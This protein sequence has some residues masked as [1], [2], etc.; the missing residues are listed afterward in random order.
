MRAPSFPRKLLVLGLGLGLLG[1]CLLVLALRS[2]GEANRLEP[3]TPPTLETA[4]VP[5]DPV[6]ALQALEVHG[7]VPYCH[8]REQLARHS[9][10]GEDHTHTYVPVKP[11]P[12]LQGHAERIAPY[13]GH[14]SEPVVYR[15]ATLLCFIQDT[16][17][18]RALAW[19]ASR[20]TCRGWV[21]KVVSGAG[22]ALPAKRCEREEPQGGYALLM[23]PIPPGPRRSRPETL[24]LAE[25]ISKGEATAVREA[26]HATQAMDL[27][28]RW[29]AILA[30]MNVS[31]PQGLALVLQALLEK[32]EEKVLST[33]SRM[34][35]NEAELLEGVGGAALRNVVERTGRTPEAVL[36][37]TVGLMPEALSRSMEGA[38]REDAP[39][40]DAIRRYAHSPEGREVTSDTARRFMERIKDN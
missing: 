40:R 34:G 33:R 36:V 14:P 5:A 7:D 30:L 24:V 6:R 38:L 37:E 35:W 9:D 11:L 29:E 27:E 25:R 13:L 21:R 20:Y 12:G 28:Q 2:Q 3:W 17:S 18:R 32:W 10:E 8:P 4:G 15:A 16:Q 31:T 22:M 23:T 19:L 26:L 39:L 1:V